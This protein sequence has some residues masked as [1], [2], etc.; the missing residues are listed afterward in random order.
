MKEAIR[1]VLI[2]NRGE[3]AVRVIRTCRD[4]GIRTVAVYADSDRTAVHAQMADEAYSLDGTTAVETYLDQARIL[5]VAARSGADAIHPGYGFLSENQDFA[6]SVEKAGLIFIGPPAAA[7]ALLGDKTA[8]RRL[9]RKL[10]IPTLEGSADA[11]DNV[12][13]ALS[14]IG[15]LAF[16]VLL[17]AAAGGGGKGMRIVE[18]RKEFASAF[19]QASSEALKAFGDPRIYVERYL[20]DPHHVEVQVL[21]DTAGSVVSLPERDCSLQ[22]RHQ[23]LVEESPSPIVDANLRRA[24]GEVAAKLVAAAGYVNAGTVEFLVDDE[25]KFYFLEVNTRLQVEHPVTEMI[26]GLDLV[27]QQIHIAEGKELPF[28]QNDIPISGHALECRI[29]AEDPS[30]DFFPSTGRLLA[31]EPPAGPGIRVDSGARQGDVVGV[32][33]DPLLAKVITHGADR[34]EAIRRMSRALREFSVAGI[35]TTAPF[36]NHVIN[37]DV[38]LEGRHTTQLLNKEFMAFYLNQRP[39]AEALT[40]A[41]VAAACFTS[42]R[43]TAIVQPPLTD[44][45]AWRRRRLETYR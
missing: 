17:K 38:F 13:T 30:N 23:K 22:R 20:R 33:F 29:Y 43:Q 3:I 40:A 7:I 12:E 19:R 8:A 42:D 10:G 36:C 28:R 24:M 15:D 18:A 37:A 27:R 14:A 32:H 6:A 11:T 34:L 45:Q 4:M 21:A 39:R 5:G 9:A 16:P 25:R 26:T 35:H 1:K 31:F 2:A 41:S 44:S